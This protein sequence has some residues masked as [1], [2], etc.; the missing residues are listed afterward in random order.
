MLGRNLRLIEASSYSILLSNYIRMW[1]KPFVTSR[2]TETNQ[3][4][5][6]AAAWVIRRHL[7]NPSGVH[8]AVSEIVSGWMVSC[9]KPK[10]KVESRDHGTSAECV[11]Y[12]L[13]ARDRGSG[14]FGDFVEL[15]Q[16]NSVI[17]NFVRDANQGTRPRGCGVPNE[18]GGKVRIQ[19]SVRLL[20]QDW[21]QMVGS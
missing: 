4:G 1:F 13:E 5:A 7:Y 11:E 6:P 18:S 21:V 14:Y 15:D 16:G 19:G 9:V 8:N 20:G 10:E 2:M 3:V 12:F 17:A